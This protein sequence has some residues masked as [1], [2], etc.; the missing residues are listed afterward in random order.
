[1]QQEPEETLM[2]ELIDQFCVATQQWTEK[3]RSYELNDVVSQVAHVTG[4]DPAR[5]NTIPEMRGR[6][7]EL[8]ET[9]GIDER[10][11]VVSLVNAVEDEF[12]WLADNEPVDLEEPSAMRLHL[13]TIVADPIRLDA[14]IRE[15]NAR[16]E[17]EWTPPFESFTESTLREMVED[18]RH[19]NTGD[20]EDRRTRQYFLEA[21]RHVSEP[22]LKRAT[23]GRVPQPWNPP[24]QG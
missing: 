11:L 10:F 5:T 18:L 13:E 9:V 8:V 21:W 17:Q 6:L 22:L 14:F 3:T 2:P 20:Y 16:I 24:Y 19:R 1:M 4:R 12:A 7:L 15:K 23:F